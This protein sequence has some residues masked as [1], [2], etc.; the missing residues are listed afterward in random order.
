MESL[1]LAAGHA[2]GASDAS[3]EPAFPGQPEGEDCQYVREAFS[4]GTAENVSCYMVRGMVKWQKR[5][6]VS[7]RRNNTLASE[8]GMT[9]DVS[10]VW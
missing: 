10:I 1:N 9:A 8:K 5:L 2:S 4:A 6:W 3:G 7:I